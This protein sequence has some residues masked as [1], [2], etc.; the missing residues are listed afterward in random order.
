M[1]AQEGPVHGDCNGEVGA[2]DRKMARMEED[3]VPG[4]TERILVHV[5]VLELP[6]LLHAPVTIK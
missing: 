3:D 1:P 6:Q 2:A 5:V 4:Y